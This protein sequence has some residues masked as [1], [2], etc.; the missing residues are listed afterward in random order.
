MARNN[1]VTGYRYSRNEHGEPVVTITLVGWHV[2]HR[3]A[4][5]L[6]SHQIEFAR[7][8]TDILRV[9]RRRIGRERWGLIWRMYHGEHSKPMTFRWKRDD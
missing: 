7:M 9:Q 5:N 2:I 8:G 3:F 1:T 6:L 4:Y